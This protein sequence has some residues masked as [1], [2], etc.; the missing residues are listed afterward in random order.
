M[1]RW[2][3]LTLE[4]QCF[5]FPFN[6]QN[7]NERTDQHTD[8]LHIW[9][10]NKEGPHVCRMAILTRYHRGL[11]SLHHHTPCLSLSTNPSV[12]PLLTGCLMTGCLARG[13]RVEFL[14]LSCTHHLLFPVPRAQLLAPS[15]PPPIPN[16]ASQFSYFANPSSLNSFLALFSALPP[17]S[18]FLPT[19]HH[20]KCRNTE[21]TPGG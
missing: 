11:S 5:I 21:Y 19:P 20:A 7:I 14:M 2:L 18:M 17:Y 15:H 10:H 8:T 16:S 6:T 4:E 9:I 3:I 12:N 13:K 1:G